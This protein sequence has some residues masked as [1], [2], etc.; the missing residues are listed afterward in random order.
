MSR[1]PVTKKELNKAG[2]GLEAVYRRG[3]K[4]GD[5]GANDIIERLVKSDYAVQQKARLP[6]HTLRKP[7][8]ELV[9]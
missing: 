4:A 1:G 8:G 9:R 6:Q 5:V 2:E 7:G 3:L